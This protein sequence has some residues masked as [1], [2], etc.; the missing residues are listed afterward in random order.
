MCR[1]TWV[2]SSWHPHPSRCTTQNQTTK[3]HS[4][5][6]HRCT[7]APIAPIL[8]IL[9]IAPPLTL[10]HFCRR[11]VSFSHVVVAKFMSHGG[12]TRVSTPRTSLHE[13]KIR[14]KKKK[15]KKKG[16]KFPIFAL[17]HFTKNNTNQ[18]D[19]KVKLCGSHVECTLVCR[20]FCRS[21]TNHDHDQPSHLRL[22]DAGVPSALNW[23]LYG[24][25][26]GRYCPAKV[27]E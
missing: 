5:S 9:P 3:S 17:Q 14:E 4:T 18:S 25:P 11:H 10:C 13:E 24:G 7:G 2:G 21:N 19:K 16:G 12:G 1:L 22:K 6:S 8:P 26:E 23:P 27:Y 15:K 20:F